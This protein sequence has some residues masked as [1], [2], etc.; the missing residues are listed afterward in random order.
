MHASSSF[1][2]P[3]KLFHGKSLGPEAAAQIRGLTAEVQ[4][5]S[6]HSCC[7]RID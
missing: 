2:V 7:R 6:I 3:V 1:V 4:V 5:R